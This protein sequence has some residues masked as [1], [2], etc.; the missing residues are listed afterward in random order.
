MTKNKRS[1]YN[2]LQ[3]IE[4]PQNKSPEQELW[5]MVLDR[6]LAD[7]SFFFDWL[8]SL[9]KT[10]KISEPAQG[11]NMGREL[12]TLEWFLFS[13]D[14]IPHN[15]NWIMDYCYDGDQLLART[16][17]KKIVEKHQENL[18]RNQNNPIV[19]P[20]VETFLLNN[21]LP[22][23]ENVREIKPSETRWTL[24]KRRKTRSPMYH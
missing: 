15:M 24:V 23:L 2:D 10:Y 7:Y 20:F 17:R 8:I 18:A 21:E 22:N 6:A 19:K 13:K 4:I 3:M 11:M 9:D 16:I 1:P 12:R 5:C 14:S